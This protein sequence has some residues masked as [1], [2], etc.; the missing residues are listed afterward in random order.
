M[1][2]SCYLIQEAQEGKFNQLSLY[3][4]TRTKSVSQVLK[5]KVNDQQTNLNSHV[6]VA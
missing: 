1:V 3:T 6:F 5:R 4:L 2:D